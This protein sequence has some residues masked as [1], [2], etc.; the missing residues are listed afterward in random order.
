MLKQ[1]SIPLFI[2]II[3][4]LIG[5]EA[6]KQIVSHC[7][8]I[9]KIDTSKCGCFSLDKAV[10]TN[11]KEY[12][13]VMWNDR[14]IFTSSWNIKND[15]FRFLPAYLYY[16]EWSDTC[17]KDIS[18][19]CC[20]NSITLDSGWSCPQILPF[21]NDLTKIAQ[22]G[23]TING[24][25]GIFS[26]VVQ[27][28][29]SSSD[30]YDLYEF[31]IIG[32]QFG[33]PKVLPEPLN[34]KDYW[35]S[36]P[37]LSPDGNYLFFASNRP[38]PLDNFT[39]DNNLNI[40]CSKRSGNYWSMP[41]FLPEPINSSSNDET[42]HFGSD[43]YFYFSSNKEGNYKIHRVQNLIL[44]KYLDY[45]F[46]N[47]KIATTNE[48]ILNG[49]LPKMRLE[50][51]NE[52]FNGE[53]NRDGFNIKWPFYDKKHN[54]FFFCESNIEN[55]RDL[56][57]RVIDY[58]KKPT[59]NLYVEV[60]DGRKDTAHKTRLREQI[61]LKE[62][63]SG[64]NQHTLGNIT[65]NTFDTIKL[66]EN[67]K[68][69]IIP[70]EN[71]LEYARCLYKDTIIS[72]SSELQDNF[73]ETKCSDTLIK[74][75]FVINRQHF[76]H[77]T[78]SN[79]ELDAH[80]FP[81]AKWKPLTR[82][83]YSNSEIM[84]LMNNKNKHKNKISFDRV[85]EI[86]NIFQSKIIDSL[87]KYLPIIDT[88][89]CYLKIVTQGFTDPDPVKSI[90]TGSSIISGFDINGN[91]YP[92]KKGENMN[93]F[94]NI[95]PRMGDLGNINLAKLRAYYT[96]NTIKNWDTLQSNIHWQ[97]ILSSNRVLLDIEGYGISSEYT[98]YELKRNSN[99]YLHIGQE[100]ELVDAWT[101]LPDMKPIKSDS[102][103]NTSRI[104]RQKFIDKRSYVPS[105]QNYSDDIFSLKED[106]NDIVIGGNINQNKQFD[107]KTNLFYRVEL[108][109][110][111]YDQM[112]FI[113]YILS[114]LN[115]VNEND[116]D[117][118]TR[119][120]NNDTL[121]V[122]H[123]NCLD[124]KNDADQLK[125]KISNALHTTLGFLG[126]SP[127]K[128][129]NQIEINNSQSYFWITFGICSTVENAKYVIEKLE[130]FPEM[131]QI[132]QDEFDNHTIRI[133]FNKKYLTENDAISEMKLYQEATKD[134]PIDF[135]Y[136]VIKVI[137]N[138][139]K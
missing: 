33:E 51:V 56:N 57:I 76:I 3:S 18:Q 31:E 93:A 120:Y 139:K 5:C 117:V 61:V 19:S 96:W 134:L 84:F 118:E 66:S 75:V 101:T 68:Y 121:Y 72:H 32:D 114:N 12:A 64:C 138:Y 4:F 22:G 53:I 98:S 81:I 89:D 132:T 54:A 100:E 86:T 110:K 41:I 90:Y 137:E 45:I 78:F 24:N 127:E 30:L 112:K 63:S 104:L 1:I 23:M 11:K 40:W 123:F 88:C 15:T 28:I 39:K 115:D 109:Y 97:N 36:Q 113:K 73:F 107:D 16:T 49:V 6:D 7:N 106:V 136:K 43:G 20:S 119:E 74:F 27:R 126:A 71:L 2:I 29:N 62:I 38:T 102:S 44:M 131:E 55:P 65:I 135:H 69:Q 99:I 70:P 9:R 87:I 108:K 8:C 35:D 48:E 21:G 13:P 92:I 42:P 111:N 26:A 105:P 122:L 124:N 91:P 60:W 103:S 47:K 37:S 10:N 133:R 25:Y 95:L 82:S 17:F 94:P 79:L 130:N 116:I 67:S 14:L 50:D 83:N 128:I 77:Q 80:Y 58:K 59:M 46:Q 129:I 52:A 34:L 125:L 85:D